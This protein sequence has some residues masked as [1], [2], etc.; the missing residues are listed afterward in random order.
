MDTASPSLLFTALLS[1]RESQESRKPKEDSQTLQHIK[2]AQSDSCRDIGETKGMYEGML[3]LPGAWSKVPQKTFS[4]LTE[5]HAREGRQGG[6]NK[7][8]G[9]HSAQTAE[10][11]LA[12]IEL[13]HWQKTDM[14]HYLGADRRPERGNTGAYNQGFGRRKYIF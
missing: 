5:N 4:Q 10:K 13:C 9:H 2:S 8:R 11:L 6:H 1:S 12:E 3:V 14:Q 7:D